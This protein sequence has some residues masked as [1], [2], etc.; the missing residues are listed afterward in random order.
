MDAQFLDDPRW[1]APPRTERMELGGG[2]FLLRSPEP[3]QP[4]ARCIGVWVERW[5]LETP[6]SVALMER[7]AEGA[8][9]QV[10]YSALRQAVGAIGQALIDME[11]P[12]GRPVVVLS[13]DGVEQTYTMA[14][15]APGQ[16]TLH[17]PGVLTPARRP[18]TPEEIADI[19]AKL[20]AIEDD[21]DA[22]ISTAPAPA[23]DPNAPQAGDLPIGRRKQE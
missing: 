5:A 15:P 16:E 2:A 4:Y 3:L 17:T 21:P 23:V 10:T 6:R 14:A 22:P 9:H 8:W 12:P 19:N 18:P 1:L 11:L 13:V 7:D 20:K